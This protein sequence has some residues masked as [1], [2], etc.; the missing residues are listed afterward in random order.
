MYN[1]NSEEVSPP[2]LG[3]GERA[4][5]HKDA[6]PMLGDYMHPHTRTHPP[7]QTLALEPTEHARALSLIRTTG[8]R[9]TSK[10]QKHCFFFPFEKEDGDHPPTYTHT[11]TP[12]SLII[13]VKSPVQQLR[14]L[15]LGPPS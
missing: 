4:R 14:G 3:D 1:Q 9:S 6:H 2:A 12:I 15:N 5:A 7:I 13:Q 10:G 11:H 8:I